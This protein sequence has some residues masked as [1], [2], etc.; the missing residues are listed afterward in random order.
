METIQT[1]NHSLQEPMA[2]PT[3]TATGKMSAGL[4]P[5]DARQKHG[6]PITYTGLAVRAHNARRL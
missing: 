2:V 3:E 6:K 4:C 1:E 5:S